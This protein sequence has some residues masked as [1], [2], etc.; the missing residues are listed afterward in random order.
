MHH[1]LKTLHAYYHLSKFLY[2]DENFSSYFKDK[3]KKLR[4]KVSLYK[5]L[6]GMLTI[7]T[8][9]LGF[10]AYH[11]SEGDF[12]KFY[13]QQK[14]YKPISD[15]ITNFPS[16][17]EVYK[18]VEYAVL[19]TQNFTNVCGIYGDVRNY[20]FRHLKFLQMSIQHNQCEENETELEVDIHQNGHNKWWHRFF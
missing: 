14:I 4:K 12:T 16:P 11:V 5:A 7:F 18:Y 19:S 13:S 2:F 9:I 10:E 6:L 20:Y 1:F 17:A 15:Q 8:F 3:T